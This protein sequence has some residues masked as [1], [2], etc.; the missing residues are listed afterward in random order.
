M[1]AFLVSRPCL[2]CMG[3]CPFP[4]FPS[5]SAKHSTTAAQKNQQFSYESSSIRCQPAEQRC[6][7]L[8]SEYMG[9]FLMSAVRAHSRTTRFGGFCAEVKD[10]VEITELLGLE[11]AS[12]DPEIFD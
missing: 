4:N 1:I 3:V 11:S 6:L 7:T 8:V 10:S 2:G 9:E 12:R 5:N